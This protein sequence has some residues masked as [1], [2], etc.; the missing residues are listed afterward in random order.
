MSI[1][2]VQKIVYEGTVVL[3]ELWAN[4]IP[5]NR[6]ILRGYNWHVLL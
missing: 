5:I 4:P 1:F 2:T 3:R 6:V